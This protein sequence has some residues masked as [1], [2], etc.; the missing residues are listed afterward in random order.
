VSDTYDE[1]RRKLRQLRSEGEAWFAR[2]DQQIRL[3]R[4]D[5]LS[6]RDIGTEIGLSATGV[7]KIVKESRVQ[8]GGGR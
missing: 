3:A 5:G 8:D 1:H 2:R 4:T 7:D 6:L